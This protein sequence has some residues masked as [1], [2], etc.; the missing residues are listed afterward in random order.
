MAS[1]YNY[2]VVRVLLL[3]ALLV[4]SNGRT[5]SGE[6][7]ASCT[8]GAC[9][10][11]HAKQ[12]FS[13]VPFSTY[14]VADGTAN[15]FPTELAILTINTTTY[16][17]A[18]ESTNQMLRGS[19]ASSTCLLC[20]E[21]P[22]SVL[23]PQAPY[24]TTSQDSLRAGL[25][26]TQ[27]TPAGDY[28]WL[29][30]HY[31]WKAENGK[32]EKSSGDRHGHNI[33]AAD[34]NYGVDATLQVAPGGTYPASSL[35]CISCHDPH[36]TSRRS[37]DGTISQTGLPNIA[38]G[39]YS[40][41]PDPDASGT[42][43]SYRM[44]AGKGY[45][46]KSQ[47]AVSFFTADPPVAVAPND[48]N[49]AESTSDTRVAYGSGM[50]EWCQNCHL[51]IHS[52]G[53]KPGTGHPSGNSA[54]FPD[55]MIQR[56]NSYIKTGDFSGAFG[57]SYTSVVPFE[58]G[59]SDYSILKTIANSDG[60]N[61]RAPGTVGARPN[62]MCLS[63]HRAHASGWDSMTRWNMNSTFLVY[64]GRYPGIDNFASSHLAQ[65]R[66]EA[67]VQRAF[68]DRPASRFAAYQRGLCNKCH[69]RD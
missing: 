67:E 3:A 34:F 57:N 43:R 7:I 2:T 56:Y 60:S 51:Q 53:N 10:V 63:C 9:E 65:G 69:N 17:V 40:N 6:L 11:C 31:K 55:K 29:K 33:I 19:D 36:S 25:A 21:A 41:S 1:E 54:G 24:N 16:P 38:T 12:E 66:T 64:A 46:P 4:A 20:H 27:L 14:P 59:T 42:A 30:K 18:S 15:A 35:S 13:G 68:Y 22:K 61:L 62:V 49:R 52:D 47:V 39:S 37:A 45:Q 23:K 32:I 26:P 5:S 8:T 58:M 50:S 44:L 48:Y 28:G